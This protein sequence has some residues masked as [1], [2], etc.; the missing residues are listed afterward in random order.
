MSSSPDPTILHS[1][2]LTLPPPPF[3]A[4]DATSTT[5]TIS[6]PEKEKTTATTATEEKKRDRLAELP[7]H[8]L[9]RIVSFLPTH[10][11][12]RLSL[13]ARRFRGLWASSPSLYLDRSSLRRTPRFV[14]LADR[15]LSL[16][17]RSAPLRR[18][19]LCSDYSARH[20]LD[21]LDPISWLVRS[22]PLGLRHLHL[23]LHHETLIYL[24]PFILDFETLESL[25]LSTFSNPYGDKGIVLPDTIR[26]D[27]LRR[28]SLYLLLE[29]LSLSRLVASA[30][31]LEDL[32]L[33][34]VR[35]KQ[36]DLNAPNLKSL[37]GPLAKYE[38]FM[39][40]L[41]RAR[42]TLSD[43]TAED[44]AAVGCVIQ[45]VANVSELKIRVSAC[46]RQLLPV[47]LLV[48]EERSLPTFPNLRSLFVYT[49][50]HEINIR[51]MITLLDHSPV[52]DSLDLCHSS[53]YIND[54]K[55]KAKDW[56]SKLPRNSSG[57]YQTACFTDLRVKKRRTEAVKL[58]SK[59]LK[60]K[61]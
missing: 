56:Q 6:W 26:L 2:T 55:K 7:E 59:R 12:V 20:L 29:P 27:R 9:L 30:P 61:E 37:S 39:P 36:V 23:D 44:A 43:L 49:S 32:N 51:D 28:L 42:V 19:R 15:F 46:W 53:P 54:K 14:L 52:L 4:D 35:A 41:R 8:L 1:E 47:R 10:V 33:R 16:R 57:N 50:F 21:P 11:A 17:D 34:D 25:S 40:S 48:D 45:S 5:A 38:G 58:L 3:M 13:L 31:V 24:L 18:L 60:I 22:R